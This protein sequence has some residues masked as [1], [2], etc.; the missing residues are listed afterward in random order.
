MNDFPCEF[1]F[2][3]I[4]RYGWYKS[5]NRG[6]NLIGV[7]RDHMYSI[8]KGFEDNI[9]PEIISHPANCK[10]LKHTDNNL[11]NGSCSITLEKLF[12]KIKL[13]DNKYRKNGGVR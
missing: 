7:S 8:S 10:L 13:W 5:T 11:K 3:L 9:D 1:D 6:N 12:E 2:N 4:E